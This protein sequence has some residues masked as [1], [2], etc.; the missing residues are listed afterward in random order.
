MGRLNRFI[1]QVLGIDGF[2]V[3]EKYWERP[4]GFRFIPASDWFAPAD[5]VLVFVVGRRWIGRCPE[6]LRR[7]RKV[8]EHLETR[9]W[10]DL[11]WAGHPV[12][13]EYT[14]DRLDC[15]S[16]RQACV[17]LL[18]WAD[19]YQRETKR[20]QQ[21]M[22]LQAQSMPTSHVAMLHAVDWHTVR[23][24]EKQALG[25]WQATRVDV[26]LE[27]V[28]VDEK[29]LGR[30]NTCDDKFVTIVS[31]L[32]T[33]EPLWIGFGRRQATLSAWLNTLSAEAKSAIKLFA[34]DMHDPFRL[35][36]RADPVLANVTI[37]H[38]PF[39]IT[40]RAGA[41]IDELRRQI[42]F[43]AGPEMRAIGRGKRW[44]VLRAWH[45]CT[46]EQRLQ[47]RELFR[48]NTKLANAY[49]VV[50]ELREV[51]HAP[52]ELSMAM[53]LVHVLRRTERRN[54][55]PMRKLHDSLDAHFQEIVALGKFH[56]PTGRI[57]AL[58]NNWETTVR[59]GR[60]YRD[61]DFLLLKLRFMT[62]NPV[63]TDDG[64]RRF[65]A[66]GLPVPYRKAA[67]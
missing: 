58:N 55:A 42:F 57:E 17:E 35:A 36:I 1:T 45:N 26:P 48:C 39:H 20:L 3:I 2:E 4:G 66:L 16:C 11:P 6:C 51:L 13:I 59:Q 62:A 31:N 33:G 23:R 60:G 41:A 9:R 10:K 49:Q 61:L 27:M 12:Q 25:R 46:P 18:P 56:P 37:T 24:A 29:Y 5:A 64:V 65:L 52:E 40:K 8:H 14:P 30:R 15:L 47:L 54:N 32:E 21:S 7:C 53:G 43:R 50:E 67:A 22:A 19:R 28:G 38:D 44:L 63:R 34:M